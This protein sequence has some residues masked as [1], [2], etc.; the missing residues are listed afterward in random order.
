[1][2]TELWHVWKQERRVFLV[3]PG[4]EVIPTSSLK[5]SRR[6]RA[7][8]AGGPQ[9]VE[10]P[11]KPRTRGSAGQH[12]DTFSPSSCIKRHGRREPWR[13]FFQKALCRTCL[14]LSRILSAAFRLSICPTCFKTNHFSTQPFQFFTGSYGLFFIQFFVDFIISSLFWCVLNYMTYLLQEHCLFSIIDS[15]QL[16]SVCV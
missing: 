13:A 8:G 14:I 10:I 1:M 4:A 11:H 5:Q 12:N 6:T 7:P 3:W 9:R 2:S 15:S 16:H